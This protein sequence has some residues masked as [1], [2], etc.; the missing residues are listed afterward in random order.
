MKYKDWLL[1]LL[2]ALPTATYAEDSKDLFAAAMSGKI[3]RTE[4]LLVKGV[5]VNSKTAS[6][7]TA[8]MAASFNGNVKI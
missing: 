1:M 7:R 3:D 4:A 5:D 2:L 6:G 8:L